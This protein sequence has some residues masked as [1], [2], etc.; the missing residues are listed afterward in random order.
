MTAEK[1]FDP[2]INANCTLLTGV[3]SL[4]FGFSLSACFCKMHLYLYAAPSPHFIQGTKGHPP[5]THLKTVLQVGWKKACWVSRPYYPILVIKQQ[6]PCINL[7]VWRPLIKVRCPVSLFS[8]SLSLCL[9]S[10]DKLWFLVKCIHV[11]A[12]DELHLTDNSKQYHT[13]AAK[14]P[15][16]QLR[17]IGADKQWSIFCVLQSQWR[18]AC[19][20]SFQRN[21]HFSFQ[22]LSW[23]TGMS[24]KLCTHPNIFLHCCSQVYCTSAI[25]YQYTVGATIAVSFPS[26]HP[27]ETSDNSG[28]WCGEPV[29]NQP[30]WL[31]RMSQENY[32][33]KSRWAYMSH[34]W[35]TATKWGRSWGDFSGQQTFPA[36]TTEDWDIT[37]LTVVDN[38]N[39]KWFKMQ[40]LTIHL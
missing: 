18:T 20:Y 1:L 28:Y 26:H 39:S 6:W 5:I 13:V 24:R 19:F 35:G 8:L 10:V 15:Q 34:H 33:V 38:S 9:V 16:S 23:K 37:V 29:F 22:C 40:Q 17:L 21:T 27:K 7:Q 31:S 36:D 12:A 25:H 11:S 2:G 4:I 14:R 32:I 3:K 30:K